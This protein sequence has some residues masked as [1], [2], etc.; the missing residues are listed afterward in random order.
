M[1]KMTRPMLCGPKSHSK[2][3]TTYAAYLDSGALDA[4]AVWEMML[5]EGDITEE[6]YDCLMQSEEFAIRA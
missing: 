1:R 2:H 6:Q 5:S 4:Q 3:A